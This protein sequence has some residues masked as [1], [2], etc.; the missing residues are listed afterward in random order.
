MVQKKIVEDSINAYSLAGIV[1]M[2]L[3]GL[4]IILGI[5]S[6]PFTDDYFWVGVGGIILL[7]FSLY[8]FKAGR[9]NIKIGKTPFMLIIVS[10]VV[11]FLLPFLFYLINC[12]FFYPYSSTGE[13]ALGW[14]IL[15]LFVF[16]P[17]GAILFLIGIIMIY[18]R[19]RKRRR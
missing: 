9:S 10:F 17:L 5:A 14:F 2:I 1:L 8:I 12:N 13:C 18:L 16:G 15:F 7:L 4:A 11:A 3:S 6:F 19:M